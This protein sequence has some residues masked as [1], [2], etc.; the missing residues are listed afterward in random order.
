MTLLLFIVFALIL[1]LYLWPSL[2]FFATH[3]RVKVE[4]K[5]KKGR[6]ENVT[7]FLED[8][9]PLWKAIIKHKQIL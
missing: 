3:K 2:V 4:I 6:T 1:L 8:E 7:L 9:D 5:D